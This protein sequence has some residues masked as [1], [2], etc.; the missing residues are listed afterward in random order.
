MFSIVFFQFFDCQVYNYEDPHIMLLFS[1][2]GGTSVM[3]NVVIT[4]LHSKDL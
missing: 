3:Y 1:T 2:I 4:S